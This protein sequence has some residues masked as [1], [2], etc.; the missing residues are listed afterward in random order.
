MNG[1]E[2][3]EMQLNRRGLA[4]K[5]CNQGGISIFRLIF[6]TDIVDT[7][8]EAALKGEGN[9][10]GHWSPPERSVRR[11]WLPRSQLLPVHDAGETPGGFTVSSKLDGSTSVGI[12]F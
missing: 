4:M 2:W 12:V 1:S 8:A 11:I 9:G 3:R 6:V 10:D 5:K 7:P